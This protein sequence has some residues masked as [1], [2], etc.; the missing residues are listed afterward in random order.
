M[1]NLINLTTQQKIK[2]FT[3]ALAG[4]HVLIHLDTSN[5]DVDIP[6]N[7]KNQNVLTLKVSALF[8]FP[9]EHDKNSIKVPLKFG[10]EYYDCVIPWDA[11]LGIT[12]SNGKQ[13]LWDCKNI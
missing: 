9:Q 10:P 6:S 7:F 13:K 12:D 3:N 1:N 4:D 5:P 11:V 2:Y 8:R